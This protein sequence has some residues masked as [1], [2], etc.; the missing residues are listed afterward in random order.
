MSPEESKRLKQAM[1]E[2]A[3]KER[4]VGELIGE[5]API[6]LR[7]FMG[8]VT[9]LLRLLTML[10]EG[11]PR[12]KTQAGALVDTITRQMEGRWEDPPNPG[13]D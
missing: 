7:F 9:T 13:S 2:L 11:V 4:S 10:E 5:E 12:F 3:L 6:Q 8:E 1:D